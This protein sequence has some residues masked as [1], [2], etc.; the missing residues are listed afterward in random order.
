MSW[1]KAESGGLCNQ[2][3]GQKPG[4]SSKPWNGQGTMAINARF[5][6]T[7]N[8][9][10]VASRHFGRVPHQSQHGP[11]VTDLWLGIRESPLSCQPA[12]GLQ[13][14]HSHATLQATGRRKQMR[15]LTC[16]HLL[17]PETGLPKNNTTCSMPLRLSSVSLNDCELCC[18]SIFSRLNS[19]PAAMAD[20]IAL[21]PPVPCL[22]P[23]TVC[24]ATCLLAMFHVE[25]WPQRRN[26]HCTNGSG[27]RSD[28]RKKPTENRR[29]SATA[30]ALA[31]A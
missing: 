7:A 13:G 23:M 29:P 27:L 11:I 6:L 2:P 21:R 26:L 14:T 3:P 28:L 5:G 31:L 8:R 18:I 17:R 9:S 22:P 12:W 20:P 15:T 24:H 1:H 16:M 25:P 30:G 4:R 19:I 10:A